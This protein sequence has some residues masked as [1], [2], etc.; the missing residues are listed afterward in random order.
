DDNIRELLTY[1]LENSGF[2]VI[3]F[4]DGSQVLEQVLKTPPNLI[5][6]DIMMPVVDGMTILSKLKANRKTAEI[7][8]IMLTAKATELDKIK[9][10]DTGA[11]D[12]ITKPFSVM[13]LISRVKVVL[14]RVK[15]MDE[16]ESIEFGNLEINKDQRRVS[17]EGKEIALTY[18]EFELLVFLVENRGKVLSRDQILHG[19]WDYAYGGESRTVDM[20][21]KSLRKKLLSCGNYVVT[22]RNVGYVARLEG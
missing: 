13:E 1:A 15:D 12:Y 20:H 17:V 2:S 19:V 16:S 21:I 7:P 18:K 22:V 11:D 9:G 4:P 3:P 5:V 10:L 8:V 6:L 14:R